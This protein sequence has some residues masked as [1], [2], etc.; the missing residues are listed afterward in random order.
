MEFS[1]LFMVLLISAV[2][3]FGASTEKA[4]AQSRDLKWSDPMQFNLNL[5][6]W[7]PEAPAKINV[8]DKTV[9]DVPE[10]LDTILD[11]LDMTAMFEVE[12]H[13][14]PLVAFANVVYYDGTYNDTSTGPISNQ[15]RDW[16]LSEEVWAIKYGLGY[17]LG[18]WKLDESPDSPSLAIYPWVGAFYFHD[19]YEVKLT[20][21][22]MIF[23]GVRVK[24]T[25]EF[26]TLMV[27]L[28]PRIQFSERWYFN[29]SFSYGGWEVDDVDEIYDIIANIGYRFKMWEVSSRV[30]AGYRYLHF[31]H[32][33]GETSIELTTKG[34]FI[35][36]GW[37][38]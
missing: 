5:Y 11:S 18:S 25:F 10:D 36:I 19:D 8:G 38:F 4:F 16:E 28:T 13:K 14:G 20:P 32:E 29:T 37:E 31:E 22:N 35:G 30:F 24:G 2:G 12:A 33:D 34:P 7:L 21:L 1:K 23:D 6:G 17:R 26:N 3:L 9:V 15:P 27:G